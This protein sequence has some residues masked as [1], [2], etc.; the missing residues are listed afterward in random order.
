M[1]NRVF[2][3]L[4]IPV[5]NAE[6]YLEDCFE[7]IRKQGFNDYEVIIVDD[8]SK[9][10]SGEICDKYA[11]VDNRVQVF[12]VEN[13]GPSRARNIGFKKASGQYIYC[14]DND[15][16]FTDSNYFQKIYESLNTEAVDILLTGASYYKETKKCKEVDYKDLPQITADRPYD[17]V[18]WLVKNKKYETSCWTKV[19]NREF[20]INNEF[21]FDEELLVED[22][23]W[24]LRFLQKVKKLNVLRSSSYIHIFRIGSITSSKGE[25][26][27]KSCLD[28]VTAISRWT[29]YFERYTG[30]KKLRMS[31]LSFLNYQFFIT[32][33]RGATLSDEYREDIYYRLKQVD[34]ITKYAIEKRVKILSLIYRLVG[35]SA[36]AFLMEKYYMHMRT[37]AK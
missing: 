18:E 8:G 14:I 1:K 31:A 20:L 17:I 34:G 35:F 13:G 28:Q 32:L 30:D 37:A 6:K 24:N 4:I 29:S 33:G 9:D 21:F 26:A 2:L 22:L 12:H 7:S 27:Y 36:T 3:S 10:H 5:Y 15:D 16:C 25:R 19:I 11:A 23:D